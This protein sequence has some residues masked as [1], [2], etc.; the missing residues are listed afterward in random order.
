MGK[1]RSR[2]GRDV[3]AHPAAILR[4]TRGGPPVVPIRRNSRTDPP[5]ARLKTFRPG[6]AADGGPDQSELKK[7]D[8]RSQASHRSGQVET[9]S[10][11][12][13]RPKPWP[14]RA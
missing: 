12:G 9:G 6:P 14:P 1:D 2:P 4:D 10:S 5:L 11:L 7:P 8:V 13:R 3:L